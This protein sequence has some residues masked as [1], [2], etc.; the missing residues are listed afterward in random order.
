MNADIKILH[1]SEKIAKNGNR[2]VIYHCLITVGGQEFVRKFYIF[3]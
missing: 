2:Y 1:M 3:K